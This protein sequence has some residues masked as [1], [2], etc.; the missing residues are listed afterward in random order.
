[1]KLLFESEKIL[2]II[3]KTRDLIQYNITQYHSTTLN[4]TQEMYLTEPGNWPTT[5]ENSQIKEQ[6]ETIKLLNLNEKI[7][8][9]QK[10][11]KTLIMD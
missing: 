3:T 5:S 9:L 11:C 8:M 2:K 6:N 10:K 4:I 7:R 1:M